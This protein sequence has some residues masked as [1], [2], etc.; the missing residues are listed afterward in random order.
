MIQ[1]KTHDNL[2]AAKKVAQF[3]L[4]VWSSLSTTTKNLKQQEYKTVKSLL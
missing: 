4:A 3:L 1:Y 2:G